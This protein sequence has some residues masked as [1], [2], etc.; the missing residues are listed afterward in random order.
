MIAGPLTGR[1]QDKYRPNA[2][3]DDKGGADNCFRFVLTQRPPPEG[4]AKRH[5]PD[6]RRGRDSE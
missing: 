6:S 2:P 1:P 3:N 5:G 4:D